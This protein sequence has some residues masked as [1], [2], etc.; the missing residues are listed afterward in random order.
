VVSVKRISWQSLCSG[1]V[2]YL[3]YWQDVP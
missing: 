2:L 3:Q 1:K